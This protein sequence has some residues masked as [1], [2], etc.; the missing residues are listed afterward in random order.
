[1]LSWV[2]CGSAGSMARRRMVYWGLYETQLLA[3][4]FKHI[5]L[6]LCSNVC[7][8]NA[9]SR[10]FRHFQGDMLYQIWTPSNSQTKHFA[11]TQNQNSMLNPR[12]T[13]HPQ[14]FAFLHSVVFFAVHPIFPTQ[15]SR[16]IL[17]THESPSSSATTAPTWRY[18]PF[19]FII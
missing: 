13:T 7:V 17:H 10:G 11:R 3:E 1:M 15:P 18:S 9:L 14:S 5:C 19:Q 2:F 4:A 12:N 6:P 8:L 16:A